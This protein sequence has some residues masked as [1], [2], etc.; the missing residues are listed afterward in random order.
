MSTVGEAVTF[1]ATVTSVYGPIPDGESVS[2]QDGTT[3]LGTGTTT[4]GV[5]TFTTSSLAHGSHS[6]KAKYAGDKNI[7]PGILASLK[8][9]V[10]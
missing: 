9:R 6:V 10:N 1:T 5:A 8:Q 3:V 4:G 2:F 7:L